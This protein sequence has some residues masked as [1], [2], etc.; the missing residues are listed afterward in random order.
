MKKPEIHKLWEECMINYCSYFK[1]KIIDEIVSKLT[2][3]Q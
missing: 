2:T 1:S 3:K